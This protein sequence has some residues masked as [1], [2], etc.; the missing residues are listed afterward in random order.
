MCRTRN[1]QKPNG[2]INTP[3]PKNLSDVADGLLCSHE[4]VFH[5]LIQKF[6]IKVSDLHVK[7]YKAGV[8]RPEGSEGDFFLNLIKICRK[9]LE[10]QNDYLRI[11]RKM[12]FDFATYNL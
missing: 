8:T 1:T 6:S 10:M 4:V 9:T 2:N 5:T 11:V 12:H 7:D 3:I